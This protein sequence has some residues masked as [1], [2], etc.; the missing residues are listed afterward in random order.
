MAFPFLMTPDAFQFDALA[1]AR[2][3]GATYMRSQL[4]DPTNLPLAGAAAMSGFSKTHI[5]AMRNQG[6]YYALVAPGASRGYRYPAWQFDAD[7]ARLEPVIR[8]LAL[9]KP[10]CWAM[11]DFLV[12]PHADLKR[13]PRDC[14]LDASFSV[15]MYYCCYPTAFHG[16]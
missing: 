14:I 11:H 16:C 13:S 15:A 6:R 4:E 10:G 7:I 2:Q 9:A 12:R 5:N 3:R 1:A 8:A